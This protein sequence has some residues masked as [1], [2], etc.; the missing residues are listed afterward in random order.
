[1]AYGVLLLIASVMPTEVGLTDVYYAVIA[2]VLSAG[3]LAFIVLLAAAP[4]EER[5]VRV[6]LGSIAYLPL[7][8]LV[9]VAD[10]LLA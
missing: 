3:F 2:T 1:M 9:M 7:L 5:A 10:K 4:S 8:F 6:F